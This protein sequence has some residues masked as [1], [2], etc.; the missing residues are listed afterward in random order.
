MG[1]YQCDR[2]SAMPQDAEYK[3]EIVRYLCDFHRDRPD[4]W[5]DEYMKAYRRHEHRAPKKQIRWDLSLNEFWS[6]VLR[7]RGLCEVT[8]TKFDFYYKAP[9]TNTK[10][11]KP[12][13]DRVNSTLGYN[14]HNVRLVV[15]SCNL[16]MN[17]FGEEPFYEMVKN[18]MA[19][20]LFNEYVK[21][22]EG[23]TGNDNYGH[24]QWPNGI[25]PVARYVI[26]QMTRAE[27]DDNNSD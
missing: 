27:D 11:F 23:Y 10:P 26:E 5:Y 2:A 13:L 9:T 3:Q 15:L 21:R 1:G 20:P 17:D 14:I 6:I 18:T 22:T 12:S 24:N 4:L 16:A 7:A 8:H 25:T 19:S